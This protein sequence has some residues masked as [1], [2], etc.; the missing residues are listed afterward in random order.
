M[1]RLYRCH[2]C[3]G[4]PCSNLHS[5]IS[6]S[7]PR[8]ALS[9]D[10]CNL[11]KLR[12]FQGHECDLK[13]APRS[14][15]GEKRPKMIGSFY[16][17]PVCQVLECNCEKLNVLIEM[18]GQSLTLMPFSFGLFSLER[19]WIQRI[20]HQYYIK[21]RQGRDRRGALQEAPGP[22][23]GLPCLGLMKRLGTGSIFTNPV[24]LT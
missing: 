9:G 22:T 15:F 24:S 19:L 18:W 4:W 17:D 6:V 11:Q 16:I 13:V 23:Q 5:H 12:L 14:H 21:V 10:M 2:L 20:L 1:F 3:C 8:A 7:T